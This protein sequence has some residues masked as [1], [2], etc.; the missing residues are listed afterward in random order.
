MANAAALTDLLVES[1]DPAALSCEFARVATAQ[2][3]PWYHDT[4]AL[5][6]EINALWAG[7]SGARS[8]PISLL[9]AL[10]AAG[11]DP[12]VDVGYRRY[13]N[14]LDPPAAFWCD[15]HLADRVRAAIA[16]GAPP[17][18][19]KAPSRADFAALI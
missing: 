11:V 1:D 15:E 12:V 19:Q 10:A 6:A 14:L 3:E 9:D 17:V 18:V 4:V 5:D 13:R 7:G 8:G 16:D 2:L